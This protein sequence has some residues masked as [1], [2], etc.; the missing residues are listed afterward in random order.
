MLNF[1]GMFQVAFYYFSNACGK[2]RQGPKKGPH[3]IQGYC[4]V[5]KSEHP[6]NIPGPGFI[7]G[8]AAATAFIE[9]K[10][11]QKAE[12]EKLPTDPPPTPVGAKG[13]LGNSLQFLLDVDDIVKNTYCI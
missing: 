10:E 9:R 7:D 13:K 1:A 2:K 6:D 4:L 12:A 8:N 3:A 5:Q 11:L